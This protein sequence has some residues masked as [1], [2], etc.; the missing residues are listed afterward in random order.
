MPC[1]KYEH[2][3]I[4]DGVMSVAVVIVNSCMDVSLYREIQIIDIICK[5]ITRISMHKI[6]I[7][8]IG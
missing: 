6:L 2:D 5:D 7:G 8:I 4:C 3:I 1:V